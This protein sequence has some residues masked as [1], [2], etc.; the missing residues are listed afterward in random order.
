M[1]YVLTFSESSH[2]TGTRTKTIQERMKSW[3]LINGLSV[4]K[5]ASIAGCTNDAWRDW[6]GGAE[7]SFPWKKH[8][9]KVI[10]NLV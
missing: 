7:V 4:E 10:Q 3:R 1:S 9:G 8:I 5:A 2:T 6:E